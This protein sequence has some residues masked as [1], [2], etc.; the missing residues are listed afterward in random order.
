MVPL[1]EHATGLSK[2]RLNC[3]GPR[4]SDPHLL[5]GDPSVAYDSQGR[6]FWTYL[7]CIGVGIEIFIAQVNPATGAILAGYPVKVTAGA[8][9]N[10]PGANG[11]AHHEEWLAAD[12][13]AGGA[14]QD[15]LYIVWTE[16]PAAGGTIV[17]TTFSTDQG[18]TWSAS[19]WRF[20]AHECG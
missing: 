6:L 16:F 3:H 19:L 7:G 5:C 14:F 13:F 20:D 1:L 2:G 8:D 9:V 10:L 15:R 11:F 12:S 4:R 17:R 18:L